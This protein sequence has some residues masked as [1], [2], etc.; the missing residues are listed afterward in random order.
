MELPQNARVAIVDNVYG[1]VEALMEALASD[2]VPVVYYNGPEKFPRQPLS[3]VRL[4]FL[5]LELKG[6]NGPLENSRISAAANNANTLLSNCNGP[7]VIV[8]WTKHGSQKV[9]TD[10]K[11]Y[12]D[13]KFT[14]PYFVVCMDKASC[15]VKAGKFSTARIKRNLSLKLA[16]ANVVGLH[17]TW[18]NAVFNGSVRLS[19]R[20]AGLAYIGGMDWSKVMSRAFY[21]LYEANSGKKTLFSFRDQFLSACEP[22]GKSLSNEIGV[23]LHKSNFDVSSRFKLNAA[24][25]SDDDEQK[26]A[27]RI[28]SLLFYDQE[29]VDPESP[30][31]VYIVEAKS[32]HSNILKALAADFFN[33]IKS[34]VLKSKDVSLCK[35]IITPACDCTQ[36]KP[37]CPIVVTKKM[38]ETKK[39]RTK[40]D[41]IVWAILVKHGA[42]KIEGK[43]SRCYALENFEYEGAYYDLLI[44]L[45]AMGIEI[46]KKYKG[47]QKRLFS[48]TAQ[49]L[50]D[51]QSKASNQLNRIGICSV[52]AEK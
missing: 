46:V 42:F 51:L 13:L 19:H 23:V 9:L 37:F 29:S 28:N 34:E 41:R 50:A 14:N 25:L 22:Y 10:F 1:E 16:G 15:Q 47:R 44:G 45:D 4:L 12:L 7:V 43:K 20:V 3:G 32:R 26:L 8:L 33:S 38:R 21:K 24:K 35:I 36:K 40:F 27:G 39:L 17:T 6:L 52:G 48:L 5:D 31:T 30:G 11:R 18:E 2:G 49:V